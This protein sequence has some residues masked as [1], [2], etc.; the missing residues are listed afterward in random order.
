MTDIAIAGAVYAEANWGRWIANCPRPF[1][2]NAMG[3]ERGQELFVC[4]DA[5]DACGQ[6]A[7]IIW[8]A[9]PDA[10]EAL[11]GFRPVRRTQNW[12]PSETLEDLLAEN[13]EHDVFPPEWK[14]I[15]PGETRVLADIV[16]QRLVGGLLLEALPAAD[17]RRQLVAA[18]PALEG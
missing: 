6:T 9:D 11:L 4:A 7:A 1:C 8:P 14:L 3:L 12:L 5:C 13:V 17:P 16:D 18:R 15:G 2:T 10:I